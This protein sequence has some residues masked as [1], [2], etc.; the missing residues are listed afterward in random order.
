MLTFVCV[1]VAVQTRK[2]AR[3]TQQLVA[4]IVAC[5]AVSSLALELCPEKSSFNGCRRRGCISVASRRDMA[6][7]CDEC[8]EGYRL[9][10]RGSSRAK[11]GECLSL[12]G[13]K[14]IRCS[15]RFVSQYNVSQQR[16]RATPPAAS[17]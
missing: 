4:L 12:T 3:S 6:L 17:T 8:G 15:T 7:V 13:H 14:P 16:Y 11:C 10:N 9:V 2:M 1:H 5:F